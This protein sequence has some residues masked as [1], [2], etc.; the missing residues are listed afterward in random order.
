MGMCLVSA[1]SSGSRNSTTRPTACALCTMSQPRGPTGCGGAPVG[2]GAGQHVHPGL[3]ALAAGALILEGRH[4]D[5]QAGVPVICAAHDGHMLRARP[6]LRLRRRSWAAVVKM[7]WP[8]L[9]RIFKAIRLLMADA[10]HNNAT[11][12]PCS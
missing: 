6:C 2:V 7:R 10:P 12:S 1:A 5:Q 9:Q 3:A 4:V 8:Q 11:C